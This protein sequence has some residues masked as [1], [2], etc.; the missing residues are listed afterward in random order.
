MCLFSVSNPELHGDIVE[1]LEKV[2]C[3]GKD[4]KFG[5]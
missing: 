1:Y 3:G 4:V 2:D 5:S